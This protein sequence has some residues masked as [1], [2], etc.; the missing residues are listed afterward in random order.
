MC[1]L[2]GKIDSFSQGVFTKN[3]SSESN[4]ASAIG[5]GLQ[6]DS[7]KLNMIDIKDEEK[8][9]LRNLKDGKFTTK[10]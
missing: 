8:T 6:N 2:I 3:L 7:I 9:E 5:Q 4:V 10:Y 1:S